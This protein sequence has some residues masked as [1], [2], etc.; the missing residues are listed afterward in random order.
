[1]RFECALLVAALCASS[2][3]AAPARAQ[4]APAASAAAAPQGEAGLEE[5]IITARKREESLQDAPIQATAISEA[6]I[7]QFDATSLEKIA[8][9]TPQL[10]VAR[11]S[12]GEQRAE[13]VV[14]DNPDLKAVQDALMKVAKDAVAAVGAESSAY[15]R[16]LAQVEQQR[17]GGLLRYGEDLRLVSLGHEPIPA[18]RIQLP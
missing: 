5:I 14:T 17:L 2:T 9:I 1:M 10:F 15:A 7:N 11:T 16:P 8:G 4:D 13:M 3:V 12:N 6:R 18:G